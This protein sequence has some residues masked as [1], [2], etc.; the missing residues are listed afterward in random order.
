M[1]FSANL[2]FSEGG[3]SVVG[4]GKK[5]F[6]LGFVFCFFGIFLG[7]SSQVGRAQCSVFAQASYSVQAVGGS[8]RISTRTFSGGCRVQVTS[9]QPWITVANQGFFF[10][11]SG[12]TEILVQTNTQ[13]FPRSA[14]LTMTFE[15]SSVTRTATISQ[16]AASSFCSISA[17]PASFPL[18][19][20][21][22]QTLPVQ[23][24]SGC[25]GVFGYVDPL[26]RSWIRM[27]NNA[28]SGVYQPNS[29][30]VNIRV[31]QNLTSVP[32]SGF[33]IFGSQ[34]I[35]INQSCN[36]ALTP[37]SGSF[38]A[39]GG[40]GSF[41][42]RTDCPWSISSVPSWVTIT[43]GSS[44]GS[45]DATVTFSVALNTGKA[46]N[47]NIVVSGRTFTISQSRFIGNAET[48][49]VYAN[50]VAYLRNSNSAGLTDIAFAYGI[51]GDVPI[52]GDW[53]GDGV[54]TLG[55]YRNG[56]FYLRNSNSTGPADIQFAFGLPG[57]FPIA[58][59]WDGDGI[60]TIGVVRG[61]LVSLNNSN[62]SSLGSPDLTFTYG[63]PNDLY[64]AGDWDGD[65]IDSI[66]VFRP[67]DG[68]FYLRNS[69]SFGTADTSFFFGQPDDKP[70]AGDW[71]ADGV[72]TI[73]VFRGNQWLLRNSN[74]TG[75]ADI[76][77][78]YGSASDTPI[79]GD[80]N[81]LP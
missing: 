11:G 43:S 69:N 36:I 19:P 39:S 50:G 78:V 68:N 44:S 38:A 23:L 12:L 14:T 61:T 28:D 62:S 45:G 42:I 56:I 70:I 25:N 60:D 16:D 7:A 47:E 15:G 9:N 6:L 73:G 2:M 24:T 81:F 72:D 22:E 3:A 31:L 79:V 77:F 74:T 54:D 46:R 21:L 33:V 5:I 57:D 17:T 75:V 32:R 34:R 58:G 4:R 27:P 18:L 71:N 76:A 48:P 63:S 65:G 66:G 26:A 41:T 13:N 52:S 10:P 8:V 53:N 1:L 67:S 29:S 37:A 30:P 35:D 55:I 59:D 51:T 20:S 64:V 49:G 80:W 40:N